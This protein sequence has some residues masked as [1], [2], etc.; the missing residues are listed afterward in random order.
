VTFQYDALSR[1]TNM[2]DGVGTTRYAYFAGGQLQSED[3]PWANDTVT[4]GYVNRLRTSLGLQQ[5]TG[6]WTNGFGYDSAK[7]LTNVTS[8][9]GSFGYTYLA[10]RS[11]LSARL[12][13]PNGAYITNTFDT[14]A[15]LLTNRLNSSS[16]TT[17]DSYAYIYNPAS[18]R[19]NVTRADGSY[20]GFVYDKIGQLTV[21]DRTVNTEDRGY[22]YDAAWNLNRLT[23]NGV[24]S[25]FNVDGKNQLTT[26]PSC[27]DGYDSNGNLTSRECSTARGYSYDDENRLVS[28]SSGSDYRS[29]F[30]Y[31]G[32]GRLRIRTEYYWGGSYWVVSATTRYIYDGNRV[33]QER[34]GGNNPLEGQVSV[35]TIDTCGRR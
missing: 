28:L 25:T 1:L 13:L 22:V 30:S 29:D 7:R 33:I 9:A 18:Q 10:P 34:D 19:T 21:A 5:P 35:L 27:Q 6:N 16:Q 23:N 32:L 26:D 3:G 4:N 17:L 8:Q 12:A 15:R 2:V 11:L 14:V 20:Y 24:I 31:D